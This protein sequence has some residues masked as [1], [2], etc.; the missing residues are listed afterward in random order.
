MSNLGVSQFIG[1]VLKNACKTIGIG[2]L[3]G[4]LISLMSDTTMFPTDP[5]K[6]PY[7]GVTESGD[8]GFMESIWPTHS[9]GFPYT[10]FKE[11]PEDM[12]MNKRSIMQDYKNWGGETCKWTFILI[13]KI[14]KILIRFL[15]LCKVERGS[16]F[17]NVLSSLASLFVFYGGPS[18]IFM[19]LIPLM[20][21]TLSPI[22][23][24]IIYVYSFSLSTVS[25]NIMFLI[26]IPIGFMLSGICRSDSLLEA[27][28]KGGAYLYLGFM[29]YSFT[30]GWA[31]F[32]GVMVTIYL[33]ITFTVSSLFIK[34]RREIVVREMFSFR[35]SLLIFFIGHTLIDSKPFL[36]PEVFIG[37]VITTVCIVLKIIWEQWTLLKT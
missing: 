10:M 19:M 9:V 20:V 3:G 26:C 5:T 1:I 24:I 30:F 6:L 25:Q 18:I 12:L 13:R 4:N 35:T 2:I 14:S 28:F 21:M 36:S 17:K 34:T 16:F 22:L 7:S 23:A 33:V 11:Q 8:T 32:V 27:V 31:Y 37:T 15:N 29:M